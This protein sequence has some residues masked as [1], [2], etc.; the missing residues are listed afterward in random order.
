MSAAEDRSKSGGASKNL[1]I[2]ESQ[3]VMADDLLTFE[4][5]MQAIALR[6]SS[7]DPR[8]V[9]DKGAVGLL[10]IMPGDAIKGMR[11]RVPKVFDLAEELGFDVGD[12][13]RDTA[14]EL[15]K[16]PEINSIIG[17]AYMRE[18]LTKYGGDA[19]ATLTAYNAGPDKYDRLGSAAAMDIPEQKEYA[20]KVGEDFK[21]LFGFDLPKDLGVLAPPRPR[22]RPKGLLQ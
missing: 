6:E 10:G 18:L 9:S 11:R 15:L 14:V 12:R 13:T 1:L 8:S 2:E 3:G 22:A 16:D 21:S 5:L 7:N 19:E 20:S 17:E 4:K